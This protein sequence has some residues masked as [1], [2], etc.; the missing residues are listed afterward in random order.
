MKT[1][2]AA[3]VVPGA[4]IGVLVREISDQYGTRL[5][6]VRMTKTASKPENSVLTRQTIVR[7]A[8]KLGW[9]FSAKKN[10]WIKK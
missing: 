4:K 9:K 5:V 10:Q 2:D 7:A 1:I 8:T 6:L 3:A